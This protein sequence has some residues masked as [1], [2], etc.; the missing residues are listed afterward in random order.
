MAEEPELPEI[1]PAMTVGR[2]RA[3]APRV[4]A[5]TVLAAGLPVVGTVL[6]GPLSKPP[7][8]LLANLLYY[9]AHSSTVISG[10]LLRAIGLAALAVPLVFLMRAAADRG[11]RV[12]RFAPGLT[13]AGAVLSAVGTLA[14]AIASAS[15]SQRFADRTGI[16]YD[17]AKEL[18]KGQEVI[19]SSAAGL[20]GSLALAFGFAMASLNSMRVG[21]LTKFVGW[22][23]IL[24]GVMVVLPVFSPVP[25]IQALWLTA[26]A[27]LVYGRWPGGLPPAWEDGEAHPWPTAAEMRERAAAERD[28]RSNG[29]A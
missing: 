21:L 17:Q 14:V 12:P 29:K 2:E 15:I 9:D 26:V 24:A 5:L 8:S 4:T 28:A 23:G 13:V 1:D 11:A 3:L 18:L 16:T 19:A 22:I 7:K 25:I 10:A 27:G 20:L 6:Q